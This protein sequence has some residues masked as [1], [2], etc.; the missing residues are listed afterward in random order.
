MGGEAR[1]DAK[2][3]TCCGL[4]L[5]FIEQEEAL[6]SGSIMTLVVMP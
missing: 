4:N 2:Q 5:R 3:E 1:E 6:H